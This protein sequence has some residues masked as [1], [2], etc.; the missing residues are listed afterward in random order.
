MKNNEMQNH[1]KRDD[2]PLRV[3]IENEISLYIK[4]SH[5]ERINISKELIKWLSIYNFAYK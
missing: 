5:E 4:T 2:R 3:K 1:P